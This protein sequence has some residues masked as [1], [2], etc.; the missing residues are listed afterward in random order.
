MRDDENWAFASAWESPSTPG[1]PFVRH[2]EP[3]DFV[4]VPLQ[5]R[6]YK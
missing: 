4:A 3:L 1:E 5:T 2:D 6:N